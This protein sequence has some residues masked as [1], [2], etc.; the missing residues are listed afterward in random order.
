MGLV[1]MIP[2]D[3]SHGVNDFCRNCRDG[4]VFVVY[5]LTSQHTSPVRFSPL[6]AGGGRRRH[7]KGKDN[8]QWCKV[9]GRG[10]YGFGPTVMVTPWWRRR[11]KSLPIYIILKRHVKVCQSQYLNSGYLAD[12]EACFLALTSPLQ[13]S[14][15][16]VSLG[17]FSP[18]S[19]SYVMFL[20]S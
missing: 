9:T 8:H 6:G 12:A 1:I 13:V 5:V 18:L 11:I 19:H 10:V 17:L 7:T 14:V 16:F 4:R 2:F 15:S 20:K 3:Y